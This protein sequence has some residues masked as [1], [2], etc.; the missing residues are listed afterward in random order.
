MIGGELE[1][2]ELE[3]LVASARETAREIAGLISETAQGCSEG[4]GGDGAATSTS[5]TSQQSARI[6][7]S[8]LVL[9]NA[10]RL[11]CENLEAVRQH[12]QE[13]KSALDVTSLRLENLRYQERHY[14]REIQACRVFTEEMEGSLMGD[15]IELVSEEAYRKYIAEELEKD[16]ALA[17]AED[18][19]MEDA[20]R[21]EEGARETV[22]E[23]GEGGDGGDG[24]EEDEE[25][26]V[27]VDEEEGAA[28][29]SEREEGED[30][31]MGD[32]EMDTSEQRRK[33]GKNAKALTMSVGAGNNAHIFKLG[34]LHYEVERRQLALEELAS[35]KS[36][37]DAMAAD[38]A[39]RHTIVNEVV[40]EIAQLKAQVEKRLA[41]FEGAD[42]GRGV[43]CG[44]GLNPNAQEFRLP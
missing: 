25:G 11:I 39:K 10:H 30:T 23:E 29:A 26:Q 42:L 14:Q 35:L 6:Y 8:I 34:R 16:R 28:E 1:P 43:G 41:F 22:D 21:S 13:V 17:A 19:A 33:G 2:A 44:T 27:G 18:A 4:D 24:G 36:Q 15:G 12:T 3:A 38:I 40:A 31:D 5:S 7:S 9:K 20:D 32:A 37:R